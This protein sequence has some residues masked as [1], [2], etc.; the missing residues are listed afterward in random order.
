[1]ICPNCGSRD[2]VDNRIPEQGI[3][4]AECQ[5]CRHEWEER[6]NPNPKGD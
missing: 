2:V 3:I 5:H 1:M 4:Q 6:Y